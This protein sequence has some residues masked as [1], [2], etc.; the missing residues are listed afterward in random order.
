MRWALAFLQQLPT[1]MPDEYLYTS[2]ARSL[3]AHGT[4]SIRGAHVTFPALLQPLL[5]RPLWSTTAVGTAY[6]LVK[7]MSA[8]AMA[9]SLV[10]VF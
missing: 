3:G 7:G 9:S 8:V 10:P 5:T 2:L 6:A 4:T 1:Y